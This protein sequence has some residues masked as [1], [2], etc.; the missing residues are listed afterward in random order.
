MTVAATEAI[1]MLP[2]CGLV[3]PRSVLMTVMSGASPNHPKEA[4]EERHPGQVEGAHL[5]AFETENVQ[6]FKRLISRFHSNKS[7]EI[8]GCYRKYLFLISKIQV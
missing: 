6:L 4:K 3:S 2:I 5:Y 1:M 8:D 7:Y